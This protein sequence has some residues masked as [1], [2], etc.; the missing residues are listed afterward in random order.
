MCAARTR[1]ARP[2][3]MPL[4]SLHEF[5][6]LDHTHAEVVRYLR[7]LDALMAR[8]DYAGADADGRELARNVCNF[9]N[10]SA[11][12]HHADEERV[13]FPQ[14]LSSG[15]AD[16]VADVLRLQQDHGWL[17]EDWLELEPMLDAL[18]D[19]VGSIDPDV[20]RHVVGVFGSLYLE[21]IAL[22]ESRVYPEAKRRAVALAADRG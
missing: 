8:I 2:A 5:E 18:A 6:A 15:D 12:R 17:E 4:A 21:H 22:E 11:R 13:V 3:T 7:Q 14:L 20:L 9:F 16:L 10:D 1:P 19:G